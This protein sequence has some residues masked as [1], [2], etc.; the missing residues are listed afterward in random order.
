MENNEE[1]EFSFC[2]NGDLNITSIPIF[3]GSAST[4]MDFFYR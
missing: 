2:G 4:S 1:K 3:G